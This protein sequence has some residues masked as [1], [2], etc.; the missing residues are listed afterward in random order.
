VRQKAELAEVD[1]EHGYVAPGA[2][3]PHDHTV[4][5]EHNL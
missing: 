5:A 4:T 1:A 3:R 2:G